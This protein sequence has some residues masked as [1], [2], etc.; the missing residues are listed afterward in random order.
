MFEILLLF[1]TWFKNR[2]SKTL[3]KSFFFGESTLEEF[4]TIVICTRQEKLQKC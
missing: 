1:Q 3:P 2:Y 4:I